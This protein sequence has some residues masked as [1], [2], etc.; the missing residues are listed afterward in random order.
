MI[1]VIIVKRGFIILS[2]GYSYVRITWGR[3]ENRLSQGV[4]FF[5]PNG[6]KLNGKPFIMVDL[7]SLLKDLKKPELPIY[8]NHKIRGG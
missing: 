5:S 2:K 1:Y 8:L 3:Y 4:V 7:P 6:E